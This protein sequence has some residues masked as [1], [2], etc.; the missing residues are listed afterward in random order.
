MMKCKGTYIIAQS[1]KNVYEGIHFLKNCKPH[2]TQ[3]FR[4][5]TGIFQAICV[6]FS[7]NF[8]KE[9]ILSGASI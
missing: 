8:F 6:H 4:P 3:Q 7:N 5:V 2:V 1:V 9:L